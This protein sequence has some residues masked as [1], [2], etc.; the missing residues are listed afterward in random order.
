MQQWDVPVKHALEK[1]GWD[2]DGCECIFISLSEFIGAKVFVHEQAA[3]EVIKWQKCGHDNGLA[4]GTGTTLFTLKLERGFWWQG[5]H[6]HAAYY[7]ITEKAIVVPYDHEGLDPDMENLEDEFKN[8][9]G[10]PPTDYGCRNVGYVDDKLV[11][12]DWGGHSVLHVNRV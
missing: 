2:A 11:M 10:K 6:R 1:G 3:L 7:F 4:P 8:M 12:I 5:C 9:F